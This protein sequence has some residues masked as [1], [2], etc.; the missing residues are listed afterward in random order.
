MST[1]KVR[2]TVLAARTGPISVVKRRRIQP[3]VPKQTRSSFML[4]IATWD[5]FSTTK[6]RRQ[7]LS[8]LS[9]LLSSTS[10]FSSAAKTQSGRSTCSTTSARSTPR[11]CDL[12]DRRGPPGEF[13]DRV[14]RGGQLQRN[15]M[16]R[17]RQVARL[18]PAQNLVDV[19]G[20]TPELVR[21]V[22]SL[23]HQTSRF[24][25]VPIPVYRRQS[26]AQRRDAD[27]D[28]GGFVSASV[29]T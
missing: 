15:S 2:T 12:R 27:S 23:R 19:V 4:S 28:P 18:C 9:M 1:M 25:L 3:S 8:A 13:I 16:R 22:W 17:S 6:L 5:L 29:H 26:R 24:D 10:T 7:P 21:N 11:I 14:I 20:G